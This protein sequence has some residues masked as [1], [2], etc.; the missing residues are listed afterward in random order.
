MAWGQIS[1]RFGPRPFLTW[2]LTVLGPEPIQ[3]IIFD[4]YHTLVHEP[5]FEDCFPALAEA[6]GVELTEFHPARQQTVNDAMVGRLATAPDRAR[7]ILAAL[8]RPAAAG[9]ADRLTELERAARWPRTQPFAATLPTLQALRDRGYRLACVSDCTELM[10]RRLLEQWEF[11]RL[12]EAV[13]LSYEVGCAKPD[14]Q[15]YRRVTDALG[16]APSRCLYVGDGGSDELNG[17]RAL[18]MTTVRIDQEGA[19]ARYACPAPADYLI[20]GL[21]ELLELPVLDPARPGFPPLDL[22][23]VR[24]D[25]A[26]GGRLHSANL[27]RLRRAG[28]ASVVDLRIEEVDEAE[29]LAEHGLRF[30][31]LPMTDGDPLTQDQLRDGAAW[32]QAERAAGRKVLAHCQHGVGRSVMLIAAVLLDEG[33]TLDQAL[34]HLRQRRPRMAFSWGQQQAMEQYARWRG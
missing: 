29:R 15:I 2:E 20:V 27:A 26:V 17:A 7:A 25:L 12:F 23:W 1:Q 33:L 16:V 28:I 6:I 24:P 3:A 19:Y 18:G 13:A 32:V 34:A 31:H 11:F 9:L 5:E 10:G 21:D 22:S 30:L 14:P 4:L 8:G